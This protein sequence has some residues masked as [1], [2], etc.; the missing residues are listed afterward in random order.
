MNPIRG[1]FLALL[2]LQS[3]QTETKMISLPTPKTDSQFSI[4]RSLN[5]RRS[6]RS[7]KDEQLPL[8]LLAQLA[9][10]AQGVTQKS[11]APPNWSWGPW[12]G[13]RRTAPS[14]G[15]LYPLELYIV[16]GNISGLDPGIYKY[17]PQTHQLALVKTGDHRANLAKAALDQEWMVNASCVF[18]VTTVYARTQVKYG[19][20]AAR[21]VHIEVGHTVENICLQAVALE[22]GATMVGAFAD[23]DVKKAIGMQE[24]EEPLAI[25]P[26]GRPAD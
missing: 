17:K 3:P 7:M 14:A 9:W 23:A 19:G 5:T 2:L 11:D 18:V 26:V 10:A 22:L 16:V 25:V 8:S 15:A 12:Q 4:E 1:L 20:R 13:G 21:Y 24:E 6:V